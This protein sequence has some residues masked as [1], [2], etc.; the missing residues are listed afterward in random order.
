MLGVQ[1][2][3]RVFGG[4][5]SSVSDATALPFS[6]DVYVAGPGGDDTSGK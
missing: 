2:R 5:R 4:G 6:L 3:G 1:R